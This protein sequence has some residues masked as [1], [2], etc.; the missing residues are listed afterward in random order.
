LNKSFLFTIFVTLFITLFCFLGT[1]QLYRLQW[2][3]D[4]INKIDQGLKS[5]PIRYSE[6]ITNDYQ[7]VILNGKYNFENQIYLYSLNSN[8]QP[9]FDVITPFQT[10][11]GY[12][13]L[14]NRGW[15]NKEMKNNPTIDSVD[16]KKIQGLMRK[17]VK[18]NIFKPENDVQKNIWFT[19]NLNQI[20]EIT[21][22]NFSNYVIFLEDNMINSPTPKKITIDVPNNH[23]KYAITWYSIS[24]SILF[25][26]LYFRKQK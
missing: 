19:I 13:I 6:K 20:K 1:W 12:N 2:K 18:K 25:Y 24:I 26:F 11:E 14:I 9:G 17:I 21:G 22:K 3:E 8:G 16:K 4:L 15:I 10:I 7:R 5:T 23:L